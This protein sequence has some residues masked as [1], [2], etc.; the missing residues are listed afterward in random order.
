MVAIDADALRRG[1]C[2]SS[3][4]GLVSMF[5]LLIVS[6]IMAWKQ[7]I[8]EQF[9]TP[10]VFVL[11]LLCL[12]LFVLFR[13]IVLLSYPFSCIINALLLR[14]CTFDVETP[15]KGVAFPHEADGYTGRPG[16]IR[17]LGETPLAFHHTEPQT[18]IQ[19]IYLSPCFGLRCVDSWV[20][21]TCRKGF[22]LTGTHNLLNFRTWRR[23]M[24]PPQE[25]LMVLEWIVSG[26]RSSRHSP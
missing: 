23:G 26:Q 6:G 8:V 11:Y 7:A 17:M 9:L 4:V 1:T 19:L 5:S 21:R 18:S 20:W 14:I 3:L 12:S 15:H 16:N 25:R 22:R 10:S 2:S 13:F 24:I